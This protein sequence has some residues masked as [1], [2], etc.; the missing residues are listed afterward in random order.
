MSHGGHS[1][2]GDQKYG[3]RGKGK[4]IR[5]WAYEVTFAHPTKKEE[6]T[7]TN[8]PDWTMYKKISNMTGS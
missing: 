4:Q 1:L 6:I 5:L 3:I 8:Y 2:Y 7:F